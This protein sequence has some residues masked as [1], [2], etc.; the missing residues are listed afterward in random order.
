MTSWSHGR[1]HTCV[2][3][4]KMM[5]DKPPLA[6][7]LKGRNGILQTYDGATPCVVTACGWVNPPEDRM[8]SDISETTCVLC[9]ENA[10]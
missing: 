7:H 3:S 4:K 5:T 1:T 2:T 6:L 9:L 8:A 10:Y